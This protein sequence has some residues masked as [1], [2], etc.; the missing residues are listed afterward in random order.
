[1]LMKRCI[2]FYADD[3]RSNL[4]YYLVQD[5]RGNDVIYVNPSNHI[6]TNQKNLGLNEQLNLFHK[7]I[8][9]GICYT[10]KINKDV[11]ILK[12][13]I[14]KNIYWYLLDGKNELNLYQSFYDNLE[15]INIIFNDKYFCLTSKEYGDAIPTVVA[16]YDIEQK[17]LLDCEDYQTE[18]ILY[19]TLVDVRRSQFD[20]VYSILTGKMMEE[21]NE[22]LFKLLSFMLGKKVDKNNYLDDIQQ[23]R[24]YILNKYPYL[25][26]IKVIDDVD[27]LKE[28]NYQF[29][30]NHF[31]FNRINEDLTKLKYLEPKTYEKVKS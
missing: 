2:P 28:L 19:K 22:R 30:I 24:N 20:C 8:N 31:S 12:K 13:H 11:T 21:T 15:D 3:N 4:P 25:S 27:E 9:Q 17:K 18:N 26:N 23:V 5:V 6:Y 7:C 10:Y 14:E 29:D 16:A 1:M